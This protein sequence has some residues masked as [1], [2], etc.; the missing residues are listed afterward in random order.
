MI[1]IVGIIKG[2]RGRG[3]I[4]TKHN[5]LCDSICHRE[6]NFFIF[7][8]KDNSKKITIKLSKT[9]NITHEK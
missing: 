2:N 3:S 9:Y 7:Q 4:K 6:I 8:T 5:D 1:G